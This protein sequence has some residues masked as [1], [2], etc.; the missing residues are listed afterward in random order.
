MIDLLRNGLIYVIPFLVII[1]MIVTIHELGHFLV[2]RAFG[3]AVDRFSIGFGK[4][5][6]SRTD[7]H[8]VEWRIGWIPAGGYVR[9]TGDSN[10]ASVPN[11]EELEGLR[12]EIE[13]QLG[14][15]EVRKFYH[16]K[17]VWQRA[18]IAAAGPA[19][20]FILA[21]LV[22]AV[23]CWA[24][25]EEIVKPQFTTIDPGSAAEAAG[26]RPGDLV[27]SL[28][29]K[30]IR[31]YSDVA[32]YVRLRAEE[33]IRFQILRN[34]EV[35]NLIVTPRRVS[36]KNDVTGYTETYGKIGTSYS[37]STT[38]QRYNPA[39]ALARGT[40]MVGETIG[41]TLTYLRRIVTGRESAQ[42]LSGVVGMADKTG[43]LI[44]YVSNAK[45]P[46]SAKAFALWINLLLLTGTISVGLGFVNLLPIPVLD[47]GHL[48]FYAYEAV[49]RR[50]A[51]PKLQNASFRVG[52]ALVL[53]LM[54][55]ANWNDLQRMQAFKFLDGLFS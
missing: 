47:G 49:A 52:L 23:L 3:V 16:F 32:M 12:K 2:A 43:K 5:I 7:K 4:A 34:G 42:N 15:A 55:F 37:G 21:A 10:D 14:E 19:A 33:P 17:P 36:S 11:Q 53:C 44:N 20:N 40:G 26:L 50:P 31:N 41:G 9:F 29:G 48:A 27:Q 22:F 38:M 18:L 8:G 28:N 35:L 39:Q 51:G 1:T 46:D 6:W 13:D 25:G 24:A 30:H 45:A 54:L